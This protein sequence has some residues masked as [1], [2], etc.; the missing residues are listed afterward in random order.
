M[1]DE[2]NAWNFWYEKLNGRDILEHLSVGGG[3]Y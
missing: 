2:R 3:K 1:G